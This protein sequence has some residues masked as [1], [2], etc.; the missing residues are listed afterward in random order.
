MS[1]RRS[2][3][4]NITTTRVP[5]KI[6][7]TVVL[8]STDHL[9]LLSRVIRRLALSLLISKIDVVPLQVESLTRAHGRNDEVTAARRPEERVGS[10]AIDRLEQAE[11][12]LLRV[13]VEE[14]ELRLD[15]DAWC[16]A[17]E[18]RVVGRN[19]RKVRALR[20]PCKCGDGVYRARTESQQ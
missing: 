5:L 1:P 7:D 9:D 6:S 15:G 13:E 8:A 12:V 14:V 19:E 11:I 16:G 2:A 20:F 18:V 4:G 3:S 17:A 10:L